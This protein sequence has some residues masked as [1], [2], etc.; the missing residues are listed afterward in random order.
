MKTTNLDEDT[1]EAAHPQV[2]SR[3]MP[4]VLLDEKIA[5]I[6]DFLNYRGAR[7]THSCQGEPGQ[8]PKA[9]GAND[10]AGY[11]SFETT[12]DLLHGLR[13]LSDL[14]IEAGEIN[15]AARVLGSQYWKAVDGEYVSTVDRRL[16]SEWHFEVLY[17]FES[18]RK[19]D[20]SLSGLVRANYEDFLQLSELL[21]KT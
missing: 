13:L 6:I 21:P 15:L 17:Q 8:D 11:V 5:N 12:V 9:L 2:P 1:P 16:L 19:E 3:L 14:A 10:K 20:E 18:E 7:T 4:G